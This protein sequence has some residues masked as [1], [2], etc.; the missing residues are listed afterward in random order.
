MPK[1]PAKRCRN[2]GENVAFQQ[3]L[4]HGESDKRCVCWLR[5]WGERIGPGGVDAVPGNS[6]KSGFEDDP[7]EDR[8][9][10]AQP[11]FWRFKP[12][13]HF[14]CFRSCKFEPRSEHM[15][16]CIM[17]INT[18]MLPSAP[19]SANTQ[20][21]LR[22]S[23]VLISALGTP[24]NFQRGDELH[25]SFGIYCLLKLYCA[26]LQHTRSTKKKPSFDVSEQ[27]FMLQRQG[28]DQS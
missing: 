21:Q 17:L 28:K 1:S 26:R 24:G 9:D 13:L 19:T 14:F 4:T 22:Y 7:R 16:L 11:S 2:P 25:L 27:F 3:N 10:A 18:A 5:R 8:E 20:S 12:H 6:L 15:W 23:E